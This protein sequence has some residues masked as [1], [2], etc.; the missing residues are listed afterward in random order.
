MLETFVVQEVQRHLQWAETPATAWHF[1]TA[2]G[3]E[4]D[5]LLEAP[6]RRII[7]IE[8]KASASVSQSDFNGLQEFAAASGR[9]FTRSVV[10]YTGEQLIAFEDRMWAVPLGVLWAG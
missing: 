2:A 1:R 6:D 9:G 3:R 5:L 4:V 8:V 7:G 10:L